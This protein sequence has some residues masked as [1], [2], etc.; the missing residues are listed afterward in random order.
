MSS[1]EGFAMDGSS[2]ELERERDDDGSYIIEEEEEIIEEFD[3]DED[4]S[5]MNDIL[6]EKLE[7]IAVLERADRLQEAQIQQLQT[8]SNEESVKHKQ[9]VYFL[10]LE[11]DGAR[12]DWTAA[13]ERMAELFEDLKHVAVMQEK[14]QSENTTTTTTTTTEEDGYNYAAEVL[15][16]QISMVQTTSGEV[17]RS[18]KEEIADLMEDRCR[19]ESDLLNQL[20]KL[21]RENRTLDNNC[22]QRL[23]SKD[24]TIERLRE[25][26]KNHNGDRKSATY[27]G[28]MD[29]L[30]EELLRVTDEKKRAE[31]L[32]AR[33]REEADDMIQRL[34]DTNSKLQNKL[35]AL[36]DDLTVLRDTPDAQDTVKALDRIA[37]EREEIVS[38][39]ER[40]ATIWERA[41]SSMLTL[42]DCMDKLRPTDTTPI[43]GDRE[44]LLSTLETSSLIHGQVKVA[45]LSIEVRLRNQLQSLKNDKLSMTW[46]APSDDDVVE[47]M[48]EILEEGLAAVSHVEST[49][50]QQIRILEEKAREE[51][52]M[53]KEMIE[54]R[55]K[56]LEGMQVEH[57]TLANDI[58]QLKSSNQDSAGNIF[59]NISTDDL[60]SPEKPANETIDLSSEVVEQLH[61]EVHRIVDRIRQKNDIIETLKQAL[62]AHK[63]RE[64]SLKKDLKR[65]M[66]RPS[67]AEGQKLGA[68]SSS[69]TSPT[70]PKGTKH[71]ASSLSS[72][73]RP[74]GQQIG[75]SS[76]SLPIMPRGQ[77][78]AASGSSTSS[79]IR[80]EEGTE[81]TELGN[82][83]SPK[84]PKG[85][86]Q[87]D[88]ADNNNKAAASGFMTP[89]LKPKPKKLDT[90]MPS[91][92]PLSP[93]AIKSPTK[94]PTKA[95][96]GS[97]KMPKKSPK[98]SSSPEEA[99]EQAKDS[100]FM[101]PVKSPSKK[102]IPLLPSPREIS[103]A[104]I[105]FHV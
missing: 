31:D 34:E 35:E 54:D 55:S 19:M 86:L 43:K 84:S 26:H 24:E 50:S 1:D 97:K 18:L 22:T 60:T 65:A 37:N 88:A 57:N 74:K 6:Q 28:E 46:A 9:E 14:K 68:S 13:E 58:I 39:L 103:K 99:M 7:R 100:S 66:R 30:E 45:L 72:P 17:V 21:D 90:R 77:T 23:Q 52:R 32:L 105:H 95:P 5:I 20:A 49:I 80:P 104:R 10:K 11:L 91:G 40:V 51:T 64:E 71:S 36:A 85:L 56:T 16:N 2:Y 15:E 89:P 4:G 75:A 76:S 87:V 33:E 29:E 93:A 3:E 70:R 82:H 8:K 69:L 12:R 94:T 78:L 96:N 92:L 98:K 81:K 101:S 42:E 59:A 41:D 83:G 102:L 25:H 48:R 38:T 73:T 44:R 67:K 61:V 62:K 27:N 63:S 53:M 79:P 47:S